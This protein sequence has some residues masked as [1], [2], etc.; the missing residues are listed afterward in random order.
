MFR[1]SYEPYYHKPFYVWS[2]S[3]LGAGAVNFI[4]GI[5][6]FLQAVMFGYF[7]AR[8]HLDRINFDPVLPPSIDTMKLTGV[9]YQDVEFD[10]LVEE[11]RLSINF[12]RVDSPV[13]L[14]SEDNILEV[15]KTQVVSLARSQFYLTPLDSEY[16]R[17]CP[18]PTDVIGG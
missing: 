1:R 6:G 15:G 14:F 16:L 10:L 7:G 2:E 4:T 13:V 17:R 5:G 18:V 11:E 9:N 12:T 8:T 3:I